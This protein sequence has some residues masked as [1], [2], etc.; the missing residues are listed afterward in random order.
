MFPEI[1]MVSFKGN[2]SRKT[3]NTLKKIIETQKHIQSS[4][5]PVISKLICIANQLFSTRKKRLAFNGLNA[6]SVKRPQ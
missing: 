6:E 3:E 2:T 4:N 5:I 1:R